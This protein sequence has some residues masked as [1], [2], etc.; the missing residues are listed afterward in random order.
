MPVYEIT[1]RQNVWR[2]KTILVEA[3]DSDDAKEEAWVS[4]WDHQ[5]W[6]SVKVYDTDTS[7]R[8]IKGMDGELQAKR[9]AEGP[10]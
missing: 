7:V 1:L 10:D 4:H 3:E 2:S 9:Q 8:E 6:D 5:K